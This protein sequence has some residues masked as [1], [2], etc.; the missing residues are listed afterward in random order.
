M[1]NLPQGYEGDQIG[2]NMLILMSVRSEEIISFKFTVRK[3]WATVSGKD[4]EFSQSSKSR[5]FLFFFE[6][7]N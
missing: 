6:V 2:Y 7:G 4:I 3:H 1:L 5:T